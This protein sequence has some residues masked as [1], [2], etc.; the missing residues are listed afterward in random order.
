MKGKTFEAEP[1]GLVTCTDHVE[2]VFE[3]FAEICIWFGLTNVVRLAG[4]SIVCPWPM[5]VA[6]APETKPLP[7]IAIV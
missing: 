7:L 2:A 3:T 6:V 4:I 1:L 5:S